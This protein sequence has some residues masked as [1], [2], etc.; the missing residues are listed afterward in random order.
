MT[1]SFKLITACPCVFHV[2]S[3]AMRLA[4]AM[5]HIQGISY[6]KVLRSLFSPSTQPFKL[7]GSS[8]SRVSFAQAFF[9]AFYAF[10]NPSC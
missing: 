1:N 9:M 6:E 8:S 7:H 4:G 5:M 10:G 3:C 2:P